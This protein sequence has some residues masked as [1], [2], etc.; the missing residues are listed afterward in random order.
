MDKFLKILVIVFASSTVLMSTVFVFVTII[1]ETKNTSGSDW[2][3]D[4]SYCQEW[5]DY[6]E[7]NNMGCDQPILEHLAKYS[8]LLDEEFNG[9][10]L[11]QDIGLS[12]GMSVEKFNE[13]VDFIYEKRVFDEFDRTWGGPGNRH[14]AFLGYEISDSCTEDMVRYLDAYT[15]I[16]TS[17]EHL[18]WNQAGLPEHV[19]KKQFY[20]C[21]EEQQKIQYDFVAFNLTENV[22]DCEYGFKAVDGACTQMGKIREKD[23]PIFFE[24][25]LMEL[26]FGWELANRTWINPDFEIE[27]P[28]RIC[29]HII[30]DNGTELYLSTIWQNEYSVSDMHVNIEMPRDCVKTLPVTKIAKSEN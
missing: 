3:L 7:L 15:N 2:I 29:S 22:V 19:N 27:P 12:D 8:N 17:D 10:Y 5:C 16:F 1:P 6:E 23:I 21:F 13:C 11:M 4:A 28:A 30:T 25:Q 14:P 18:V 24:I 9:K 20:V 26:D